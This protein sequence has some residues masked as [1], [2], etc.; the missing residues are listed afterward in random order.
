MSARKLDLL[1]FKTAPVILI[2]GGASSLSYFVIRLLLSSY[3]Q[4]K[5]IAI[6]NFETG[7]EENIKEFKDDS[8]FSFIK[9]DLNKGIPENMPLVN[10]ILHLAAAQTH[11]QES[12]SVNLDSLLTNAFATKNLLELARS[13]NATFLLASSINVHQGMLS[14]LG[15]KDYFGPNS[16]IEKKFSHIEA[17]RYAEAL[18]WEYYK[19]YELDLRIVRLGELYG[20]RLPLWGYLGT[21]LRQVI[22]DGLINIK[23][24]GLE[25][26][27]YVYIED[28]AD[29]L[30]RALLVKGTKGKIFP[31]SYE[32]PISVIELSYL[33]KALVSKDIKISFS[34]ENTFFNIPSAKKVANDNLDIIF[35][36]PKTD[37]EEGIKKT[38][39]FYKFL[40]IRGEK[41]FTLKLGLENKKTDNITLSEIVQQDK[42]IN[43]KSPFS[44]HLNIKVP[45]VGGFLKKK[46]VLWSVAFLLAFLILPV[47]FYVLN[48][49]LGGVTL[50]KALDTIQTPS[51]KTIRNAQM[52]K[53]Y[54]LWAGNPPLLL[55]VGVKV[56]GKESFLV[57]AKH[58]SKGIYYSSEALIS[59]SNALEFTD[60]DKSLVQV[61]KTEEFLMLSKAEYGSIP[62]SFT[63]LGFQVED[64]SEYLEKYIIKTTNLKTL[65]PHLSKILGY[66]RPVTYLVLIQN[67]TELAPLGGVT[68]S[69]AKISFENGKVRD[70]V[71]D[72]VANLDT[73]FNK[74][75]L[76]IKLLPEI[77]KYVSSSKMIEGLMYAP[78]FPESAED[79]MALFKE[80]FQEDLDGVFA[81]DL[82]FI[83]DLLN[84]T[85]PLFLS[86]YDVTLNSDNIYEKAQFYTEYGLGTD[87][88]KKNFL[89]TAVYKIA[90]S[91]FISTNP[92]NP[93][94]LLDIL[95]KAFNEKHF[96]AYFK[97]SGVRNIFYKLN[98][99][100]DMS[101]YGSDYLYALDSNVG[102]TRSNTDIQKSVDYVLQENSD[103]SYKS[104]VKV[105]FTH[106]G[107][108]NSWP[109][110]VYKNLFRLY[111]PQGA[112]LIKATYSNKVDVDITKEA[113]ALPY[114]AFVFFPV[115][116]QVGAGETAS[117]DFEYS[118][119]P[120]L[121][122]EY[123]LVVQKQPGTKDTP[124]TF[125]LKNLNG[126]EIFKNSYILNQDIKIDIYPNS[127]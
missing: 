97:D 10:C 102:A 63:F 41:L 66:D 7:N 17:K 50:L 13:N 64:F 83:K 31:V 9:Y 116:L 33:V 47:I 85:G 103:G 73:V 93:R 118:L 109:G 108:S 119:P 43:I 57:S 111:V 112:Q 117:I 40:D 25:K 27:N 32:K 75:K 87:P 51:V 2:S 98:W 60:F 1:K 78:S 11:F 76:N 22:E 90:D 8:R 84:L 67:S 81:L 14:S 127:P 48:V 122:S 5:I 24:D 55:N 113:N 12:D 80:A 15:L 114:K 21:I 62:S 82:E 30:V 104:K 34:K 92:Q 72:D 45:K 38:L 107:E 35:W 20:P 123:N 18:C 96:I 100:A 65:I 46:Y 74:S 36:K 91:F 39:N 52:S 105:V 71:V 120:F 26:E 53:R 126:E 86:Y 29:A 4:I 77:S 28:A 49:Y 3:K 6:D 121:L 58:F 79:I 61:S 70:I 69:V 88:Q 54:I 106:T 95:E 101:S 110:G 59:L 115:L 56:F 19:K 37:L 125:L 94:V 124:F 44:G 23:G 99:C 42:S 16:H 68:N 89:S